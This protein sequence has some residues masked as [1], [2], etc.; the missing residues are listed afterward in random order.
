MS[1]LP[2]HVYLVASLLLFQMSTA[3][4]WVMPGDFRERLRI[5]EVVV[6]G[7]IES[8]ISAGSQTVDGVNLAANTARVR[9]DRIFQG[10]APETLLF[11]WFSLP[12]P[13][14]KGFL[15]SGPPLASFRPNNRYLIFLKRD[16]SGFV[17]AIPAD[18]LEVALAPEPPK[19]A[20]RDSFELLPQQRY[21]AL[22]EELEA[23]ALYFPAPPSVLAGE[24]PTYFS[25]VLDLIGGCAAPFYRKFLSSPSEDVRRAANDYLNLIASRH[26]TC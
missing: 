3:L 22:A 8:T 14:A 15:Y 6:S 18:A 16:K 21:D 4:P 2:L 1:A 5:S 24:A 19:N 10:K 20:L 12:A 26:L 17:T 13:D 7:T 23:A 11:T 25:P 9:V